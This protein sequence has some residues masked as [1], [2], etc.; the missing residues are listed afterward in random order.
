[1]YQI[2]DLCIWFL[3][4]IIQEVPWMVVIFLIST[5]GWYNEHKERENKSFD[6]VES[7]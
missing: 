2:I 7:T 5:G 4:E 3:Y 6:L 1:M